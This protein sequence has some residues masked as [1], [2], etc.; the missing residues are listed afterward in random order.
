[1][2]VRSTI[3]WLSNVT[4]DFG[5]PGYG[6]WVDT[7]SWELLLV[8]GTSSLEVGASVSHVDQQLPK[9]TG[10]LC[11]SCLM[12]PHSGESLR[13][14][15][16]LIGVLLPGFSLKA[17]P[18]VSFSKVCRPQHKCPVTCLAQGFLLP[19]FGDVLGFS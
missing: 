5:C 16:H 6:L 13:H 10:A 18:T 3:L 14:F 1:M 15:S 17:D 12:P 7:Q 11:F 8:L 9:G 19:L 4:I 2:P